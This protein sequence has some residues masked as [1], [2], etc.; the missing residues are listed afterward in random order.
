MHTFKIFPFF[1]TTISN[2][3]TQQELDERYYV[4]LC[5]L[6]MRKCSILNTSKTYREMF[7]AF[8]ME[9]ERQF[10]E[11]I[12]TRRLDINGKYP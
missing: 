10:R 6:P 2:E 9:I 8:Q 4:E 12:E 5:K 11:R 7:E 1:I 3:I